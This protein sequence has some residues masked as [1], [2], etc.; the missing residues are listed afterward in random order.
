MILK[1]E[2]LKEFHK[3]IGIVSYANAGHDFHRMC[4]KQRAKERTNQKEAE[5]KM[6]KMWPQVKQWKDEIKWGLAYMKFD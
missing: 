4:P 3:Q 2:L 5:Q 1:K 6:R